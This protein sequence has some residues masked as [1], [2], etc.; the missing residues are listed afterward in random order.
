MKIL[1]LYLVVVNVVSFIMYGVDKR[2][3]KRNRW[4]TSEARLLAIAVAGGSLGAWMGMYAFRHKTQHL[5]FKY[6]IPVIIGLQLG[7]IVYL[8]L[9]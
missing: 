7:A 3:A 4:R 8:L 6:G 1:I 2:K 5:K 9:S